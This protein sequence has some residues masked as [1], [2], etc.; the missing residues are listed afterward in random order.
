MSPEVRALTPDAI[1][2]LAPEGPPARRHVDY[3]VV[4]VLVS[5]S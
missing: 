3:R 1:K 2:R 5:V 4:L